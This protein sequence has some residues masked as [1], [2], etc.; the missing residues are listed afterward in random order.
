MTDKENTARDAIVELQFYLTKVAK[1][2]AALAS[3]RSAAGWKTRPPA[4]A[5]YPTA[6]SKD[7]CNG[8][9][10]SILYRARETLLEF[11]V[12]LDASRNALARLP[13][14][15]VDDPTT[16]AIDRR[17][18][19]I[20]KQ[21]QDVAA[22][23]ARTR[24]HGW[25]DKADFDLGA[26]TEWLTP[27]DWQEQLDALLDFA[28]WLAC[29]PT[30]QAKDAMNQRESDIGPEE[31][32]LALLVKHPDWTQGKMAQAVGV[33]RQ[34]LYR[35]KRYQAAREALQGGR[36]E[37]PRGSKDKDGNLEAWDS[38]TLRDTDD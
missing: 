34:S 7:P 1:A 6:K 37:I 17:S 19:I 31:R 13:T 38:D 9:W 26:F 29:L 15:L 22:S 23:L 10:A 35:F 20:R 27:D 12:V 32:A 21:L 3:A 2:G 5:D 8:S 33:N 16:P 24:P 25:P 4:E 30:E 11:W 36:A 14:S 18:T 28:D